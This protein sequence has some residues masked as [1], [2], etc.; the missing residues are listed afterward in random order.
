MGSAFSKASIARSIFLR[1]TRVTP[2]ENQR[3]PFWGLL[4]NALNNSASARRYWPSLI[5]RSDCPGDAAGDWANMDSA[6]KH[7]ATPV[8]TSVL[9][10]KRTPPRW[11]IEG[12]GG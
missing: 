5:S 7:T 1:C 3:D 9:F 4:F 12:Q 10:S 2:S 11:Q 6:K 8:L